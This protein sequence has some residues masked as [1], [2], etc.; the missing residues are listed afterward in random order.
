[1][2]CRNKFLHP[3]PFYRQVGFVYKNIVENGR[4]H[5]REEDETGMDHEN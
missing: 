2:G 4:S 3:M 1:M 5:Y